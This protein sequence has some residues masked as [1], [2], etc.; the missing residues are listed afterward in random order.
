MKIWGRMRPQGT[1]CSRTSAVRYDRDGDSHFDL[2][3]LAG[4]EGSPE[5]EADVEWQ[6]FLE[7]YDQDESILAAVGNSPTGFEEEYGEYLCYRQEMAD[8]IEEICEKYGLR[9]GLFTLTAVR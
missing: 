8:K 2:L 5:H 6:E 4:V 9:T 1:G 7:S 3:S